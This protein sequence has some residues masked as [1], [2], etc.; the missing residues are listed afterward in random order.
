MTPL[1]S[2]HLCP[3]FPSGLATASLVKVALKDLQTSPPEASKLFSACKNLGFFYLD[4][5][6]SELGETIVREAEELHKLQQRF[7]ALPHEVKDQYGQ[8]K[9]DSFFAYRWTK[10]EDGT[11]DVWDRPGRREMYNVSRLN[12]IVLLQSCLI[13]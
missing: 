7:Y 3:P 1:T 11:I 6:D 13:I 4:L 10:C 5:L 9:V 2:H 8:D 12:S